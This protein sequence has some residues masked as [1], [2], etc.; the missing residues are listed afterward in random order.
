M[1]CWFLPRVAR[2]VSL[3]NITCCDTHRLTAYC[4]G[5]R[6]I[7]TAAPRLYCLLYAHFLLPT[8]PALLAGDAT[9]NMHYAKWHRNDH[10]GGL[11]IKL[12]SLLSAS[13]I[14]Q[15]YTITLREWHCHTS[16]SICN[17]ILLVSFLFLYI[18]QNL[19]F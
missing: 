9:F 5:V 8:L 4:D 19:H 1:Q 7:F 3:S 18:V 6:T 10:K 12:H 14:L 13:C 2:Y 15:C 17:D 16:N 11:L